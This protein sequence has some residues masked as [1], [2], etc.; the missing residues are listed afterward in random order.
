MME[1]IKLRYDIKLR[2]KIIPSCN[3]LLINYV[4]FYTDYFIFYKVHI[5]LVS[6][7]SIFVSF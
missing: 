3:T 1:F 4:N 7:N 6:F 5:T 2:F